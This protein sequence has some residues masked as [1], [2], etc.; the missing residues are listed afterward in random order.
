MRVSQRCRDSDALA[1]RCVGRAG[2]M[3]GTANAIAA[4]ETEAAS[5]QIRPVSVRVR[6]DD[7]QVV[8]DWPINPTQM[9][10]IRICPDGSMELPFVRV[11]VDKPVTIEIGGS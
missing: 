11:C 4:L 5:V 9:F 10:K 1:S 7:G 2:R 6:R 8:A 3:G